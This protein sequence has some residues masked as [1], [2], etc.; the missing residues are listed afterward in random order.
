MLKRFGGV[1]YHCSLLAICF[2]ALVSS[3]T[4]SSETLQLLVAT[5]R[6][7]T[8]CR[9]GNRFDC[10]RGSCGRLCQ[11]RQRWR[12]PRRRQTLADCDNC[13][14]KLE[15]YNLVLLQASAASQLQPRCHVRIWL[16]WPVHARTVQGGNF[17]NGHWAKRGGNQAIRFDGLHQIL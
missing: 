2:G 8:N 13:G 11:R 7:R 14:P 15:Q 17:G 16:P 3:I 4:D 9:P 10:D 6:T 1:A 12:R 5:R